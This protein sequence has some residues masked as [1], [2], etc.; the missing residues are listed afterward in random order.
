MKRILILICVASIVVSLFAFNAFGAETSDNG[1]NV[2]DYNDYITNLK[3]DGDN[4][5]VT[6]I[7]PDDMYSTTQTDING[8][9]YGRGVLSGNLYMIAN[10]S[11]SN[12]NACINCPGG[13]V[14]GN[15]L[16]LSNIPDGSIFSTKNKVSLNEHNSYIDFELTYHSRIAYFDE[17]FSWIKNQSS[18][19]IN[20]RYEEDVWDYELTYEI[21]INK[22]DNAKYCFTY[23]FFDV[24][25]HSLYDEISVI[26]YEFEKPKL[27][28]SISS[29]YR[30]QEQT[31]KTNQILGNIEDAINGEATPVAPENSESVGDLSDL[32]DSLTQ[33]TEQG[34][35]E[36]E[37]VF[38]ESSDI[39][40]SHIQGF[41][42]LGMVIEWI[43][44]V[45]WLR[46][47][48]TVSLSF[49]I[50]AFIV[51][52]VAN[53]GKSIEHRSSGSKGKGG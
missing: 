20:I 49:G 46:G 23:F 8:T 13:A 25:A 22:P 19:P 4:D 27:T 33:D 32:E 7:F 36:A 16:D 1:F 18:S 52:I 47:V 50:F 28:M 15:Y 31:G 29:L 10:D 42:F 2:I 17:K 51:N 39:V 35:E 37:I 44:G 53:H 40:L 11:Q 43:F 38:N 14:G 12:V 45:G 3:V 34:R 48:L 5:I 41:F 30:L 21:A 26:S 24:W 9:S 6:V